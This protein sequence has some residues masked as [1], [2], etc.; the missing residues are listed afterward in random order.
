MRLF[1]R[2]RFR[3]KLNLGISGILIVMAILLLPIVGTMNARS[4]VDEARRRGTAL[5]ESL[6]ARAVDP[7]LAR[8][9]LRLKNMVDE[10]NRVEDVVYAFLRDQDGHV[11]AHTF[12]KG[13]PVDLLAVNQRVA[14]S[15][16]SIVLLADGSRRIYDFMAPVRVADGHIGTVRIGL[17]RARIN[18]AVQQQITIMAGLFAG[19]LIIA[20][21]MGTYFARRVTAR[22][23][24]LRSHAE[25]MLTGN[26]DTM[27]APASGVHCWEKQQCNTF[28]CPAYG[29]R[30]RRC[31]YIAGTMCPDCNNEDSF[32]CRLESCRKCA[33]YRENAGDEIQDLAE[34]FDVMALSLKRHI[35]ELRDAE[36]NLRDQQRL[37][38][39]ILDVTPDR[40][41]LVDG[42]MR[43]QGC[44]K[45][46][47]ESVGVPLDEVVGKT[48]FD[49]FYE[50][51][52]EER[53]LA[54]RDIL[55]SG[56]RLDTQIQVRGEKGDR[57]FHVVSIPVHAEDGRIVGLLRTDRDITDI[58]GFENQL[59]QAQKMESLGLMAGGVAHEINTPLGIILGYSQLLQ[60]DVEEG[61]QIQQDL[62]IIEKQ[63]QV[64]KKIVADLLGFSRQS[65]SAKREMCFN[66]SVLEA[67]SLVR[68]TFELDNVTILTQMD[69]RF[70]IIYGDPEK[71][72]Q[73]WINLLNNARDAMDGKGGTIL[74]RTK[75]DTPAG[76]V[77][78]WV[79]DSGEG[80]P[81]DALEKIFDPFYSTKSV[82]QGTG[83][84]LS[85][86]FG[87]IE[88]H[89]GEIHA[90]SPVPE[91][92]GFPYMDEAEKGPGTVFEIN[93]PLD[94]SSDTAESAEE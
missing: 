94:H 79:A 26:L 48:D 84:G 1:P 65:E 18:R 73:V 24:R 83:L 76:I 25:D 63:A 13:F 59:I 87:I 28:Q 7:M 72:K 55:T 49:L 2:L 9:F 37:T 52:A 46:F 64:C 15:G 67:V 66:N 42:T 62:A 68:H 77:S 56:R 35:D 58:K 27:S 30:Q 69:D 19:V 41:S 32:Q 10:Q 31:W 16:P 11:L 12:Q 54:G 57:W 91:D 75:L 71:L 22:L 80:I 29:E 33:V 20:T 40:V 70:P 86:S 92:F 21:T 38:R 4:L 81:E 78:V 47:A 74:I 51:E 23:G 88:D 82:G 85:V 60:E 17:S 3:T 50:A 45:S 36:R 53:H 44:N 39:T 8:D 14:E 34:T 6:A 43:Y 93:L 90:D 61:S 89:D 5:V